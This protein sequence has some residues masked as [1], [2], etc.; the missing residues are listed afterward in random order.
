[1]SALHRVLSFCHLLLMMTDVADVG[2]ADPAAR[3]IGTF[4]NPCSDGRPQVANGVHR[5]FHVVRL[6]V[7]GRSMQKVFVAG[8]KNRVPRDERCRRSRH[9]DSGHSELPRKPRFLDSF[10]LESRGLQNGQK[11]RKV[12][13]SEQRFPLSRSTIVT[14]LTRCLTL[15]LLKCSCEVSLARKARRQRNFHQRSII[16]F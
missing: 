11:R 15:H 14:E 12:T 10:D 8:D 9:V 6:S 7:T 1:M 4:L 2:T 5:A 16:L 3:V 13:R